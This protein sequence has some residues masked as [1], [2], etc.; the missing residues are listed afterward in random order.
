MSVSASGGLV[1]LLQQMMKILTIEGVSKVFPE[2][3][4]VF[5]AVPIVLAATVSFLLFRVSIL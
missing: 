5:F 4:I 2:K 1:L 3:M